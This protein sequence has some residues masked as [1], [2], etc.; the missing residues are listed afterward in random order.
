MKSDQRLWPGITGAVH[1][2][3]FFLAASAS[4]Q[5]SLKN[6]PFTSHMFRPRT[7]CS[8]LF[9]PRCRIDIKVGTADLQRTR[10][11]EISSDYK[12]CAGYR[13]CAIF[14]SESAFPNLL[15][16]VA[17]VPGVAGDAAVASGAVGGIGVAAG[18]T[19]PAAA[20]A[21]ASAL[22]SASPFAEVRTLGM[23]VCISLPNVF[24]ARQAEP[25]VVARYIVSTTT[26]VEY[27]AYTCCVG[28]LSVEAEVQC[29]IYVDVVFDDQVLRAEFC[30]LLLLMRSDDGQTCSNATVGRIEYLDHAYIYWRQRSVGHAQRV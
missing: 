24:V 8:G 14:T 15:A 1:D 10:N 25:F 27:F 30:A 19:V 23:Y 4:R 6:N 5:A 18:L 2:A 11:F 16:P 20:S 3:L 7:E 17:A 21:S 12:H 28:E 26:H 22:A 13:V 9:P 29:F